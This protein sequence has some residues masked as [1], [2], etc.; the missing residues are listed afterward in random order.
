MGVMS[1]GGYKS[2]IHLTISSRTSGEMVSS[3]LRY[4]ERAPVVQC[5]KRWLTPSTAIIRFFGLVGTVHAGLVSVQ[6]EH[7][8][9][10]SAAGVKLPGP[11][12]LLGARHERQL[13]EHKQYGKNP[14]LPVTCL[15]CGWRGRGRRRRRARSRGLPGCRNRRFRVCPAQAES[16]RAGQGRAT[17]PWRRLRPFRK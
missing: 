17:T 8:C 14:F 4:S 12:A 9:E 3:M 13:E 11:A 7:Q 2:D 6:V 5:W 10:S 1:T 16:A 15:L